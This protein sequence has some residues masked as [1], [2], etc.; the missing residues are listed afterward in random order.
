MTGRGMALLAAAR[1]IL[2]ALPAVGAARIVR[3]REDEVGL[4]LQPTHLL[5]PLTSERLTWPES[6]AWQ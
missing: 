6:P 1:R 2:T 5:R 4:G 3:R